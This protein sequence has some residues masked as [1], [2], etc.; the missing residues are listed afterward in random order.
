MTLKAITKHGTDV[1]YKRVSTPVYNQFTGK[2]TSTETST[3][4]RVYPKQIVANQFNSPNMIGRETIE[5]YIYAP[6]LTV[7]PKAND[8]IVLS[9]VNYTVMSV[10]EYRANGVLVLYKAMAVRD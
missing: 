3:S 10:R 6:S 5:F 9:A 8:K 2:S 1:T 7:A 4:I